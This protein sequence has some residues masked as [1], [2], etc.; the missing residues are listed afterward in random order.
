MTS[1]LSSSNLEFDLIMT[2]D[3]FFF[4]LPLEDR[5]FSDSSRWLAGWLAGSFIRSGCSL[6]HCHFFPLPP[7]HS[8]SALSAAD[9]GPFLFRRLTL[10]VVAPIWISNASNPPYSYNYNF[11]F[12]CFNFLQLF[13][14]THRHPTNKR[15]PLRHHHTSPLLGRLCHWKNLNAACAHEKCA[16]VTRKRRDSAC[17]PPILSVR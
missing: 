12:N 16:V 3:P 7:S 8:L 9:R 10:V 15:S 11:N 17:L 14:S 6:L 4:L 2:L 1:L 13:K 5:L